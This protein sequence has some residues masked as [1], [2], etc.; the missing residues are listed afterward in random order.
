M[1]WESERSLWRV[2]TFGTQ[3]SVSPPTKGTEASVVHQGPELSALGKFLF[4]SMWLY[5]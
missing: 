1:A 2:G 3:T 5:F 4:H